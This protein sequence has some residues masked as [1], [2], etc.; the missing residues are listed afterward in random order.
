MSFQFNFFHLF[1]C[2]WAFEAA[3]QF[4]LVFTSFPHTQCWPIE[5]SICC[6]I[7]N[8]SKSHRSLT[9]QSNQGMAAMLHKNSW[10]VLPKEKH[11][12]FDSFSFLFLSLSFSLSTLN[13]WILLCKKKMFYLL[14]HEEVH[15]NLHI[16]IAHCWFIL[17]ICSL[18][19]YISFSIRWRYIIKKMNLTL[20]TKILLMLSAWL[21]I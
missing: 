3:R 4:C 18:D 1:L 19:V 9:E 15:R 14:V 12:C 5:Q 11:S 16:C 2:V 6:L 20:S 21:R 13:D 17:Y 10:W 8:R 7:I